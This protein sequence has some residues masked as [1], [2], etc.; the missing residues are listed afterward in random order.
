[1][2]PVL[3]PEGED[4]SDKRR[5]A[6]LVD[7]GARSQTYKFSNVCGL[8]VRVKFI[9]HWVGV[10]NYEYYY[11]FLVLHVKIFIFHL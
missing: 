2:L 10:Q 8:R 11:I 6:G 9:P 7:A 4:S 1:M 3:P 5:P